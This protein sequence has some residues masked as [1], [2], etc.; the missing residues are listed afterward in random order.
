[1]YDSDVKAYAKEQEIEAAKLE[2][3]VFVHD[4]GRSNGRQELM[5]DYAR[6][7]YSSSFRRL[8]GKM[9]LLYRRRA[10]QPQSPHPQPGGRTDRAFDS[11]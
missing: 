1:M 8:Q 7:L 2:Y 6:V 3:R 5:R 11:H 10:L 9:Q 4:D